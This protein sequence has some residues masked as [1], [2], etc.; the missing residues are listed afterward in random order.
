MV[1]PVRVLLVL[2]LGLLIT[3]GASIAAERVLVQ[4]TT[5]TANSGLYDHILPAFEA[6]SG[7]RVGIVAVGTGQAIRNARNC[8]G[9][10]L[11]VHA[12]EAEAA[13][14]AAGDG[15]KRHDLMFNDFVIVGPKDDPARIF[16]EDNAARALEAISEARALFVSRGDQS[17][18]HMTERTLWKDAG[19]MQ[20]DA[21]GSWYRETGAGMGATLNTAI[22]MGAYTIVDRATWTSFGNKEDFAVAVE[23]DPRLYNQYGVTLVNPEACPNVA[24]EPAQVFIDWL[25]SETGQAAIASHVVNGEQLF[26]PN[27]KAAR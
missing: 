21:S 8:D 20:G 9:D 17:G 12:K 6:A 27:A 25:L 3:A 15:V 11:L 23:G 18:T 19:G 16:D 22:G 1:G 14:V 13:F 24:A 26:F 7:I 2:N 5:S 4:S 10:V